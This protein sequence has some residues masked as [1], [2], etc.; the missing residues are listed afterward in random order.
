[1]HHELAS[2]VALVAVSAVAGCGGEPAPKA[3]HGQAGVLVSPP[4]GM[5][6]PGDRCAFAVRQV[7]AEAFECEPNELEL[8]PVGP[9]AF[10]T[11][12]CDRLGTF[13]C[14]DVAGSEPHVLRQR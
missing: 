13:L 11:S 7:A 9:R 5:E 8:R 6:R 14:D 3:A 1:M 2:M 10:L 4:E 12:G